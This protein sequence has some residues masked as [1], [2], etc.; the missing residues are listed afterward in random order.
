MPGGRILGRRQPHDNTHGA[1]NSADD[2]GD[3]DLAADRGLLTRPKSRVRSKLRKAV[4]G[5]RRASSPDRPWGPP[6][7][8][9][10]VESRPAQPT[11]QKWKYF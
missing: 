4:P 7:R 3:V 5:D 6:D 9:G 1:R 2:S 8:T 10:S 11:T